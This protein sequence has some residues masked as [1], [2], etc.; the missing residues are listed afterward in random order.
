MSRRLVIRPRAETDIIEAALWYQKQSPGLEEDFLLE[1]DA[2]MQ[3]MVDNPLACLRLRR[4]PETRRVL[5][6][7]FPY[8]IFFLL[9]P[10]ANSSWQS[11]TC[12]TR[13]PPPTTNRS[14]RRNA[15]PSS[16]T[17]TK[18]TLS[19]TRVCM[20]RPVRKRR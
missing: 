7:R 17:S 18:A 5:V 2:A 9:Q 16:S 14:T 11:R 20:P 13:C 1:V 12:S 15:P 3:W 4:R 6:A 19:G 10:E 8:R